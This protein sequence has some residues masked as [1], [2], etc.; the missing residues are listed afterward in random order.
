MSNTLLEAMAAGLPVLASDVGGNRELIES[1]RSGLLFSSGDVGA[2]AGQLARLLASADLRARLGAA[3]QLRAH[4]EFS[5]E[6]ML[7]RYAALYRR[8]SGHTRE[9][10]R[11]VAA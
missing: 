3:A 8:V 2:L 5:L 11:R 10:D 6:A 7:A 4:S 9:S 1:E